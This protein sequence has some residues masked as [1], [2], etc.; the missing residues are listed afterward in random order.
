MRNKGQQRKLKRSRR[1]TKKNKRVNLVIKELKVVSCI[2]CD[3]EN[4]SKSIEHI[5][6]ESLGNKKYLMNK[7]EVCDK[8]NSRFSKFEDKAISNTILG[9]ARTVNGITTKKGKISSGKIKELIFKGQNATTPGLIE[10]KGGKN[11]LRYNK[12]NKS[13]ELVVPSFDKNEISLSKLLLKMG[14]ESL[15]KS[16]NHVYMDYDFD[17]LKKYLQNKTNDD[18]GFIMTQEKIGK[19]YDIPT[20]TMQKHLN[21]LGITMEYQNKDANTL[22]FRFRYMRSHVFIINLLSRDLNWTIEY[23]KIIP[24]LEVQPVHLNK[25]V[26]LTK[27]N[28]LNVAGVEA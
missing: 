28:N 5:V 12:K 25:K 21:K 13:F 27:D 26:G 9:F 10:I 23:K 3:V 17:N 2:I 6:S 8:C 4:D 22:L 1:K 19:F 20:K 11:F 24:N 7:D 14:I 18:W 15:F 16:K